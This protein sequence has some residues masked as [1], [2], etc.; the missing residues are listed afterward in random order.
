L[1]IEVDEKNAATELGE[2]CSEADCRSR[3]T[4]AAF[5]IED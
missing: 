5:L 3:L 2:R 1:R 4:Y